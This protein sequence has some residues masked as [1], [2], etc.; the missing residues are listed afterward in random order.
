M[1]IDEQRKEQILGVFRTV[2]EYDTLAKEHR[3]TA[4]ENMKGLVDSMTA[5]SFE[6]KN[7]MKVMRKAYKEWKES[8]EGT[9]DTLSETVLLLEALG[10]E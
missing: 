4:T 2:Y 5:D 10:V 7:L 6:R 8:I 9:P 1:I 3:A